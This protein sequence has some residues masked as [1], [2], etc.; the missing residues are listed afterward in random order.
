MTENKSC[1]LEF[2]AQLLSELSKFK[3][4]DF[5][6][7][8][9]LMKSFEKVEVEIKKIEEDKSK[10]PNETVVSPA[11]KAIQTLNYEGT[12]SGY[13]ELSKSQFHLINQ[14]RALEKQAQ[15]NLKRLKKL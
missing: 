1:F 7:S 14:I 5:I 13:E 9:Q 2:K 4:K 12:P 11:V 6:N 15:V 8:D 10:L 3:D